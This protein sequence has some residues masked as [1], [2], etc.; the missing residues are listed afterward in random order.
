MGARGLQLQVELRLVQLAGGVVSWGRVVLVGVVDL[1]GEL[2]VAF[3]QVVP[4]GEAG[5]T[6][7]Q[8]TDMLWVLLEQ[9]WGEVSLTRLERSPLQLQGSA[10]GY[11]LTHV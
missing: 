11:Y 7:P 2:G 4:E 1:E 6:S 9:E 8:E 3:Q 5:R 10:S